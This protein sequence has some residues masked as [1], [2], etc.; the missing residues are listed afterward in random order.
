MHGSLIV[1]VKKRSGVWLALTVIATKAEQTKKRM[2][3]KQTVQR[4][5][6]LRWHCR[7]YSYLPNGKI[8]ERKKKNQGLPLQ[9]N[10]VWQ[11]TVG[12]CSIWRK[13]DPPV[14][15]PYFLSY[16][17]GVKLQRPA[18]SVNMKCCEQVLHPKEFHLPV[19]L[20]LP[21]CNNC[22]MLHIDLMNMNMDGIS[23]FIAFQVLQP[24]SLKFSYWGFHTVFLAV[25][26]F[27]WGISP[28][29]HSYSPLD[30]SCFH[31]HIHSLWQNWAY[32]SF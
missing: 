18:W 13:Q 28:D 30:Y 10:P 11:I 17:F 19:I 8:K 3:S 21:V 25:L 1:C 15:D 9:W 32:I 20:G 14:L 6:R 12:K 29:K 26:Y 23:Q 27:S 2:P 5:G 22:I 4:E 7:N 31:F 24:E 16:P